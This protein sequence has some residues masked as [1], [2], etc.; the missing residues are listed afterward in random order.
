M[1]TGGTTGPSAAWDTSVEL[2]ERVRVGR[3]EGVSHSRPSIAS[4]CSMGHSVESPSDSEAK[5]TFYFNMTLFSTL[6]C[7]RIATVLFIVSFMKKSAL[8]ICLWL[9][10]DYDLK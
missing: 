4:S 2:R 9:P 3:S 7:Q 8:F 10:V 6:S 5:Q 1:A